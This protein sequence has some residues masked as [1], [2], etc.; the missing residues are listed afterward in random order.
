[1]EDTRNDALSQNRSSHQFGP[2]PYKMSVS[3]ALEYHQ[4]RVKNN[5][6]LNE[7][8]KII[9]AQIKLKRLDF[10]NQLAIN[11]SV[12]SGIIR[13][14]QVSDFLNRSILQTSPLNISQ[15]S[16][17][18]SNQ[19]SKRQGNTSFDAEKQRVH[20]M[21]QEIIHS[22]IER[23]R[24]VM[25]GCMEKVKVTYYKNTQQL[26]AIRDENRL[27]K[28]Q[29]KRYKEMAEKAAREAHMK[30]LNQANDRTGIIDSILY[31]NNN[32]PQYQHGNHPP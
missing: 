14:E 20:L 23:E 5:Q 7:K 30:M 12:K 10:K 17:N 13:Q 3:E 28:I 8:I 29:I 6:I 9:E 19:L 18:F 22:E 1:M 31:A 32:H 21:Y 16:L 26:N 27:L 2:E 4:R 24:N 25:Q 15:A 11:E